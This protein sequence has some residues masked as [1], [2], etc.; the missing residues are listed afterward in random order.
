MYKKTSHN[1]IMILVMFAAFL[2]IIPLR[3]RQ[4]YEK[5]NFHINSFDDYKFMEKEIRTCTTSIG[6][7]AFLFVCWKFI[8]FK[9]GSTNTS[10][11]PT[12][13][14]FSS[15]FQELYQFLIVQKH[16][17]F[18]ASDIYSSQACTGEKPTDELG[19]EFSSNSMPVL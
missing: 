15:I 19:S 17:L 7:G 14:Y 6:G 4:P 13:S 12:W 16:T 2:N 9:G 3:M 18:W 8:I 10:S 1:F 5:I 11:M